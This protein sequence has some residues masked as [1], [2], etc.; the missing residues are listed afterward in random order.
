MIA[1]IHE[2]TPGSSTSSFVIT[3]PNGRPID[4]TTKFGYSMVAD[5]PIYHDRDTP[6]PPEPV[7]PLWALLPVVC[8]S[9]RRVT[10]S[11]TAPKPKPRPE[12][13]QPAWRKGRWR[14]L[15]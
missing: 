5:S 6:P 12:I 9:P 11:P 1:C 13:R 15:T 10:I 3:D 7:P 8:R 2:F 14:S 4:Q